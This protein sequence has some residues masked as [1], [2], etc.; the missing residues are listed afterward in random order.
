[1][2]TFTVASLTPGASSTQTFTATMPSTLAT[3]LNATSTVATVTP[4]S[5]TA[6]NSSSSA[7]STQLFADPSVAINPIP[8]GTLGSSVTT[9]LILGNVAGQIPVTFTPQVSVNGGAPTDLAQVTLP[10]GATSTSAVITV[11]ITATGGTVSA[12]VT[13]IVGGIV[14]SNPGNNTATALSGVVYADLLTSVVLPGSAPAGSVA[15]GTVTFTNSASSGTAAQVVTGSVTLSNGEVKPFTAGTLAPGQSSTQTFTTTVPSITATAVLSASSMV[16]STTPDSNVGNNTAVSGNLSVLFSDPGVVVNAIPSALEG[17]SVVTTLTLSNN[18]STTVTFTP[19]VV[20]NGGAPTLLAAV[21]LAPGATAT[22]APIT[23]PMTAT[24]GTVTASV[25]APSVPD[26]NLDNN[27]SSASV[28]VTPPP[29]P[30]PPVAGGGGG[31]TANPDSQFDPLLWM[32]LLAGGAAT[33]L[34]RRRTS[35]VCE[36]QH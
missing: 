34:R 20:V 35:E 31:C 7:P 1:M 21:T 18:G 16:T 22:S 29:P 15:S 32:V 14:D 6:N 12:S 3:P 17:V 13:A 30:P 9:T 36:A 24:G 26:R 11:P 8:A 2:R 23:V 4:E 33:G 28:A 5:T 27:T 19:E 10:A 25:T